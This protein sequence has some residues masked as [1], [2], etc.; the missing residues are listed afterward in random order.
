[1][2]GARRIVPD[3]GILD[4]F[5]GSKD[6][7]IAKRVI[8]EFR[9]QGETRPMTFVA[10]D[11]QIVTHGV[12]GRQE[13]VLFLVQ[14][15]RQLE[16]SP[17]DAHATIYQQFVAGQR[18]AQLAPPTHY[19]DAR[20]TLRV[21]LRDTAFRERTQLLKITS[22]AGLRAKPVLCR[23][24]AGDVAMYVV[25]D[26]ALGLDYVTE[27]M[28]E[29]W[30]VSSDQV[31]EAAVANTRRMT[32]TTESAG[33]LLFIKGPDAYNV[34]CMVCEDEIRK[35]PVG[36]L[37]VAAPASRD[38]LSIAG[39][40]DLRS[41]EL[42]AQIFE[43][44]LG[45]GTRHVSGRPL[46]LTATGWQAFEPP[47]SLRERFLNIARQYDV[48][49]WSDYKQMLEKH[50]ASR[51]E[52]IFVASLSMFQNKTDNSAF[53]AVVWSTGIDTILPPA[54]RVG[55]YDEE[56]EATRFAEWADVLRVMG[57]VMEEMHGPPKR[58]RVRTFPTEQQFLE[59][60][61]ENV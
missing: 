21:A 12:G 44:E 11:L 48:F 5:L 13:G 35:L 56:N 14:L 17:A 3:M 19:A 1:V 31:F 2:W 33:P 43:N 58:F 8:S 10:K 29:E 32:F 18:E 46:V 26:R 41:L 49:F 51:D 61:A 4:L 37:P 24:F 54:E 20:P 57:P 59:M 55:F 28:V 15:K 42:L 36:G 39:S 53:T 25:L 23:P 60:R 45:S 40:E 27:G 9:A 30:E 7:R 52:D 22:E 34:S 16:T 47:E 6:E 50:L 38:S